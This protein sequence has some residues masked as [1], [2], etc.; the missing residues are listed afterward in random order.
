MEVDNPLL[1]LQ[2]PLA[3]ATVDKL[4]EAAPLSTWPGSVSCQ[5]SNHK[6]LTRKQQ[7]PNSRKPKCSSSFRVKSER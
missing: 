4:W 1:A 2:S 3:V 6:A 5:K 7:Y